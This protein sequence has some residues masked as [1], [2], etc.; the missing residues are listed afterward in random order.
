ME[1]L[2][3]KWLYLICNNGYLQWPSTIC[4]FMWSPFMWSCDGGHLEDYFSTSLASIRKDVECVF[5]M[6]KS[7]WGILDRGFKHWDITV[8]GKIFVTCCILH[9]MML[10]LMV[11]EE[12]ANRIGR[13]CSIGTAWMWLEGPTPSND[14]LQYNNVH[15]CVRKK[16][17]IGEWYFAII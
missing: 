1:L 8:C 15:P 12:K 16:T 3:W 11:R 2:Q 4:P 7:R 17:M 5:G 6:L 9:N 14:N 13:G 10:D